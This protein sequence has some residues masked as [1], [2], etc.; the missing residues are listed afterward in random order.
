[1]TSP[2]RV[3]TPLVRKI[4]LPGLIKNARS[5]INNIAQQRI[6]QVI[7]QGGKKLSMFFQKFFSVPLK[8]FTKRLLDYL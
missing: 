5:E 4:D 8:T 6:N 1:M 3:Q 2:M 7:I